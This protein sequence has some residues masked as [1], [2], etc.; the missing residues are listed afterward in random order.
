MS[1]TLLTSDLSSTM[2]RRA[3]QRSLLAITAIITAV[4]AAAAPARPDWAA[5]LSFFS[6]EL[7]ARHK[8]LFFQTDRAI[9][10]RAVDTLTAAAPQLSDTDVAL[11]LQEIAVSLGDDHTGVNWLQL[12]P[13][14]PPAVLRIGLQWFADGWRIVTVE[15][16]RAALLG[17]KLLAIG[18]LPMSEVEAK[19]SRLISH[20]PAIVKTRLPNVLILP[21][22][23]R[24]S[25]LAPDDHVTLR[26]ATDGGQMSDA[27]YSLR[28]DAGR[29]RSRLVAFQPKSAALGLKDTRSIL[30]S[31]LLTEDKIFYA[32]YNRCDGREV[33]E[34]AGDKQRAAQLPSLEA[35][36][37]TLRTDLRAAI[38][39]GRANTFLFDVRHNP[40]GASDFGTRFAQDVATIPELQRA[41][42]VFVIV[43]RRTFS[44][45]ILNT[46]DFQRLC[47]ARLVGETPG[48]TPN[49]YG[50]IK[51]F[52]LPSSQLPV[53][54]STKYFE[55]V[56]G[57]GLKS[58]SL[59]LPAE[60]TFADYAAGIDTSIEAIRRAVRS[61]RTT[62]P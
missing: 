47:G 45:A 55:R 32:Q 50:E 43:G 36:F 25:G 29:D 61:A 23:L 14:T 18:N 59:D 2:P 60:A 19:L 16:T 62:P 11:R 20:H 42:A 57:A 31:T 58:L 1:D 56:P 46:M 54:Y 3:L 37:A 24:Y 41:G 34:R 27:M 44:S 48:G 21:A 12:P 13:A 17:Q 39:S 15:N 28:D 35:L 26:C 52:V 38:A 51:T 5:D 22:V 33:A 9:F 7:P 6:R 53:T 40:G 8:N 30:W 10:T 49:H 4:T